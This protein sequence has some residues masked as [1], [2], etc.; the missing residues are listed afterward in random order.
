MTGSH[1][2][3]AR[4]AAAPAERSAA[5]ALWAARSALYLATAASIGARSG[6]DAAFV[7][8]LAHGR[9]ILAG[10]EFAAGRQAIDRLDV[11]PSVA[12][13]AAERIAGFGGVV[14]L[15]ALCAIAMLAL[16]EAQARIRG[17]APGW[18]LAAAAGAA[19]VSIG[20][21]SAGGSA[22]AWM[23][24][25]A[26]G[27][28]LAG[29]QGTPP[30]GA[31]RTNA[32]AQIR[33]GLFAVLAAWVWAASS[34]IAIAA[35]ALALAAALGRRGDR[36]LLA[37]TAGSA[38]AVLM[39]P[40]G[41]D[42]PREAF[43]HLA[44]DGTA[45]HVLDWQPNAISSAAYR[46]GLIPLVVALVWF[47]LPQLADWPSVSG[48]LTLAF[49]C[50]A[51]M[52]LAGIAILPCLVGAAGGPEPLDLSVPSRFPLARFTPLTLP[53]LGLALSLAFS[54]AIFSALVAGLGARSSAGVA[55]PQ[56]IVERLAAER[57]APTIVLCQPAEWCALVDALGRDDIRAFASDR[58]GSLGEPRLRDQIAI[59][60]V[61]PE[62][63]AALA[64]NGIG[65]ILVAKNAVLAT[66]LALQPDWHVVAR[67]ESATLFVR[68]KRERR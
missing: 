22:F 49:V 44:I 54:C 10:Q 56:A 53:G 34:W 47:R 33:W 8:L 39:T 32:G 43:A 63:R 48:V 1:G 59:V 5:P 42:L 61:R 60:G 29:A 16:V 40:A 28:A 3:V 38:L 62:W 20:A 51:A 11:L 21:P 57:T 46:F 13:A 26:F 19:I 67:N 17:A 30:P 37:I 25:A 58:I 45:A 18:S 4:R 23:L 9:A 65:A 12:Y 6:G 41:L 14:A 27:F 24:A 50:G 68:E 15:G 35:P 52:P 66:L 31:Q 2:A 64:R 7:R 55:L 36:T